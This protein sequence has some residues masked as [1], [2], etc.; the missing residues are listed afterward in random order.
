MNEWWSCECVRSELPCFLKLR[1]EKNSLRLWRTWRFRLRASLMQTWAITNVRVS[2]GRPARECSHVSPSRKGRMIPMSLAVGS[3][4]M[5]MKP[6]MVLGIQTVGTARRREGSRKNGETR[7]VACVAGVRKGRGRESGRETT[8]AQFPASPSPF[9]ACHAGYS[10]RARGA[11]R[12]GGVEKERRACPP[13]SNFCSFSD[14]CP[15][16]PQLL[17]FPA[18]LKGSRNDYTVYATVTSIMK[19]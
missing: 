1:Y 4:A 14:P 2:T 12:M 10:G 11:V 19:L 16:T 8:R 18:W 9:N 3:I 7:G 5:I 6:P 15:R 13:A 17:R